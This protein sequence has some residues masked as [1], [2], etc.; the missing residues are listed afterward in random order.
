LQII[1]SD[2]FSIKMTI[3]GKNIIRKDEVSSTNEYIKH[4]IGSNQIFESG[5]IVFTNYQTQGKGRGSNTWESETAKNLTF[6]IYLKPEFL[7][8]EDQ[9]L[10]N[11]VVSV[12]ILNFVRSI[13][14]DQHISIKW[15]NDI[16]INDRKIN[17]F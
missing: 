13:I 16:Y 7:R 12:G 14:M 1:L 4:C 3:I 17:S 9:F 6:S 15:P 8:A 5:D 10:L 11:K 2:Y